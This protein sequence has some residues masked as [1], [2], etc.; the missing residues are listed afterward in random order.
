MEKTSYAED[1]L[2]VG[3]ELLV[4]HGWAYTPPPVAMFCL[5]FFGRDWFGARL[6]GSDAT[7]FTQLMLTIYICQLHGLLLSKKDAMR[8]IQAEHVTTAQRYAD[9]AVSLGLITIEKSKLD[10]RIQLLVPTRTGI[11]KV[12]K[13]LGAIAKAMKWAAAEEARNF[14]E[15]RA[16]HDAISVEPPKLEQLALVADA[17]LHVE[18]P[19]EKL[20]LPPLH[21][22]K[23][24]PPPRT[25]ERYV[26]VYTETLEHIEGCVPALDARCEAYMYLGK[27]HD[28]L[29]D[30]EQLI[31][32]QPGKYLARRALLYVR[33]KQPDKAIADYNVVIQ[34]EPDFARFFMLRAEAFLQKEDWGSALRDVEQVMKDAAG[35]FPVRVQQIRAVALLQLQR[36]EDA[37]AEFKA[38][39]ERIANDVEDSD[40]AIGLIKSSGTLSGNFQVELLDTFSDRETLP[41][42]DELIANLEA[43]LKEHG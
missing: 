40:E 43:H 11:A 25:M 19:R 12:E 29:N 37:L 36:L 22:K 33:T 4:I 16:L 10:G 26:E 21:T 38:V 9:I 7:A 39:R 2:N 27:Y 15:A 34:H 35:F 8:A 3:R 24:P 31:R 32:L 6:K 30:A 13:E 14:D 17:F 23:A 41:H 1:E 28:A 20:K 18:E 5:N 42:L